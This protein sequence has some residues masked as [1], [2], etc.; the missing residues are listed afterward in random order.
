MTNDGNIPVVTVAA[1]CLPQAWEKAVL[2]VWKH[3]AE[4]KTEYDRAN[5]PPS[6]DATVVITVENPFAEPRS[7]KNFPSYFGTF[8]WT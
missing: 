6:K 1:A 3:G 4:I 5:N 8:S 7:H 2:A